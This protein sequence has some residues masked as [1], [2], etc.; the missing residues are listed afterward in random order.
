MDAGGL[1]TGNDTDIKKRRPDSLRS[2]NLHSKFL[3]GPLRL[4]QFPIRTEA[5]CEHSDI[6]LWHKK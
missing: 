5:Y 4:Q 6:E 3:S 1:Y 2:K